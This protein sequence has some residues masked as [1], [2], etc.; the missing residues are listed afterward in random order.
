MMSKEP[1]ESKSNKYRYYYE[2]PVDDLIM[3][4]LNQFR[5]LNFVTLCRVLSIIKPSTVYRKIE[6][7]K[8]NGYIKLDESESFFSSA[9]TGYDF[10]RQV[11]LDLLCIMNDGKYVSEHTDDV[12]YP[13]NYLF[14]DKFKKNNLVFSIGDEK[15]NPERIKALQ[16]IKFNKQAQILFVKLENQEI[17]FTDFPYG[18]NF[19]MVNVYDDNATLKFGNESKTF[20]IRKYKISPSFILESENDVTEDLMQFARKDGE[21]WE[22]IQSLKLI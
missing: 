18:M 2:V 13:F 7:L 8:E 6:R 17:D 11:S 5:T 22:K 4:L 1:T 20:K 3:K 14:V 16:F 12:K 15:D 21:A 19:R 9:I 10:N